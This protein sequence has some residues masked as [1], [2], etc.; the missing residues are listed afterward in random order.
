MLIGLLWWISTESDA[1]A[2]AADR[3]TAD[4][5]IATTQYQSDVDFYNNAKADRDDCIRGV[6][7]RQ[8]A[9]D[10][11]RAYFDSLRAFAVALNAP[12][13]VEYATA[14][15]KEFD[16]REHNQP[17]TV[18]KDCKDFPPPEV[19]PVPLIL[20]EEGILPDD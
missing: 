20:I 14:Q 18:E 15:Q 3:R 16:S 13:L 1:N 4:I 6:E 12:L 8:N 2:R 9:I 11:W 7:V 19:V 5:Q 17:L 10:N